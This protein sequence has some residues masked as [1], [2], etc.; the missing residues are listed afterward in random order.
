MVRYFLIAVS[1]SLVLLFRTLLV[2][3]DDAAGKSANAAGL[4]SEFVLENAPFNVGIV[5]GNRE[6]IVARGKRG[7]PEVLTPDDFQQEGN[8]PIGVVSTAAVYKAMRI[9][10]TDGQLYAMK[11]LIMDPAIPGF[12][13]NRTAIKKHEVEVV[14]YVKEHRN[15]S[16][17]IVKFWAIGPLNTWPLKGRDGN[18]GV[19]QDGIVM[20]LLSEISLY[21]FLEN[22]GRLSEDLSCFFAYQILKALTYLHSVQNQGRK[23]IIVVL[24]DLSPANVVFEKVN[25]KGEVNGMLKLIDFG[26]SLVGDASDK[27]KF[28]KEVEEVRKLVENYGAPGYKPPE[29]LLKKNIG[30]K[31]DIWAAGAIIYRMVVGYP[32]HTTVTPREDQSKPPR[33]ITDTEKIENGTEVPLS[34]A[35]SEDLKILLTALLQSKSNNRPSAEQAL[36]YKWFTNRAKILNKL[37]NKS[38]D[39]TNFVKDQLS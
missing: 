12:S 25:G 34:K 14:K 28:F 32:P 22:H 39:F 30:R 21:K 10:A 33:V 38:V 24:R 35:M 19:T 29:V 37:E 2:I 31:T 36:R 18:A 8:D 7:I 20:E 3:G 1:S 16:P 5:S 9:D 15:T 11:V 27:Q 6:L 23:R 17:F 26:L 4:V 13:D